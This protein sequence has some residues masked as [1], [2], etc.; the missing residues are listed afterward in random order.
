MNQ[1]RRFAVHVLP[2]LQAHEVRKVPLTA[3]AGE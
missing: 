1:I 3:K 2:K